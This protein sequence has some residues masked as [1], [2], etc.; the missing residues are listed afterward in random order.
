MG[1]KNELKC[2]CGDTNPD[3]FYK[4][5]KS[6]CKKCILECAK[7]KYSNLSESD[8]KYY[9]EIQNKWQD[10]NFLQFRLTSARARARVKN[11]PFEIDV[12]Y[13]QSLLDQ[14]ENKCFYS[15]IEMELNRAGTYTASVDRVDSSKGY[16]KGNVVFVISAVNTMK[17]DLL[18]KEFLS[19][20]ES[21]YKNKNPKIH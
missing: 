10:N 9:I 3:N 16:V 15:G 14:Q 1:N 17:N 5:R 11:I 6:K 12:A 13:L 7:N 21:V 8:K 18:E 19:I 2:S 20:I 4:N